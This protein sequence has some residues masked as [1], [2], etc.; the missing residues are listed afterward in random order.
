M[1]PWL[2]TLLFWTLL[3]AGPAVAQASAGFSKGSRK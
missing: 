3:I 1:Q 2:P